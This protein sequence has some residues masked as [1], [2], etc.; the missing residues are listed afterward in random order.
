MTEPFDPT[1]EEPELPT[2][3]EEAERP[4]LQEVP[5]EKPP[6]AEQSEE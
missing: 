1:T 6:A 5:I 3:A 2:T 4:E